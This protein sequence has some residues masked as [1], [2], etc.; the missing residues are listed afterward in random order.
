[1]VNIIEYYLPKMCIHHTIVK[2]IKLNN[3][4]YLPLFRYY[5]PY[6]RGTLSFVII[7]QFLLIIY[8]KKKKIYL[9]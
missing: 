8:L 2:M 3:Y 1:M 9:N 4:V 5:L 7:F 6:L